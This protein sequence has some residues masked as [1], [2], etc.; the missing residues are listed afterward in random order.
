MHLRLYN[1][2]QSKLD[3]IN[4]AEARKKKIEQEVES[5]APVRIEAK[6]AIDDDRFNLMKN[7]PDFAIDRYSESYILRHPHLKKQ[8]IKEKQQEEE[9]L[10]RQL[11]VNNKKKMIV[12]DKL[13]IRARSNSRK[14]READRDW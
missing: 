8:L 7:N 10:E 3:L 11:R 6:E 14:E 5:Q 2:F 13:K 12:K 9:K 1:K 4:Y